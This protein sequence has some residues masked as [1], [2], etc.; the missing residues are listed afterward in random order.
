MLRDELNDLLGNDIAFI[1]RR[2]ILPI[3]ILL[4]IFILRRLV[5]VILKRSFKWLDRFASYTKL[6]IELLE[7][8]FVK[9]LISPIRLAIT[10]LGLWTATIFYDL[11]LRHQ[12]TINN[13]GNTLILFSMFWGIYRFVDAGFKV[14]IKHTR[15]VDPTEIRFNETI[16]QFLMRMAEAG[17]VIFA[18]AM[19]FEEV[20]GHNL[21]GLLAGL[22]L[23]GLA[24]ALAAQDA[25]ANLI[26]Y[27][28]IIADHPFDVGDYII[29]SDVEGVVETIGFRTTQLR[30]PDR[31]VIYVPN[32]ILANDI[33]T[34]WSQTVDGP[35]RGRARISIMLGLTYSTTA[36]QMQM[37][38]G[39]IETMLIEHDHILSPTVVVH[40]VEFGASSLDILIAFVTKVNS[41]RDIQATKQNVNLGIMRLLEEQGLEV[42]FPTRTIVLE[43]DATPLPLATEDSTPE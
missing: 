26:G 3:G 16:L 37:I 11:P 6:P 12:G 2:A 39:D 21:T 38:V 14:W 30:R 10:V 31:A 7:E 36:S 19:L 4:I 9:A 18:V 23:G 32:R 20:F 43:Q 40:F 24:V 15:A 13:I 33:L 5:P 35:R 22:G 42:A 41:W 34:N 27:F 28:S 25:L 1:M 17:V 29:T 8:E